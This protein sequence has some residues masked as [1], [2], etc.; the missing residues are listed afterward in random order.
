MGF[1]VILPT[2]L[3]VAKI[4]CVWIGDDFVDI[5]AVSAKAALV[6]HRWSVCGLTYDLRIS[7]KWFK[8]F[9]NFTI[10]FRVALKKNQR[11]WITVR[12]RSN[13]LILKKTVMRS[14]KESAQNLHWVW[15]C[16]IV[17]ISCL[18]RRFNVGQTL[19]FSEAL[20]H[21]EG[22]GGPIRQDY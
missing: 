8:S 12:V 3:F 14:L 19:S 2:Y 10:L 16:I 4:N 6:V 1:I 21:A 9:I 20:S 11:N 18:P 15:I 22:D 13:V 7:N 17:V 5:L